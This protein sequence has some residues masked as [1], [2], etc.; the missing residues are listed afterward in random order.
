MAVRS[1][2]W[3]GRRTRILRCAAT[4]AS[5]KPPY[6]SGGADPARRSGR[7]GSIAGDVDRGSC[8]RGSQPGK[9]QGQQIGAIRLCLAGPR[10]EPGTLLKGKHAITFDFEGGPLAIAP[11]EWG[12]MLARASASERPPEAHVFLR[13]ARHARNI[14]RHRRSV[15][16]SA[17]AAEL[18]LARLRDDE[19]AGSKARLGNYVRERAQQIGGLTQFLS[20][21]GRTLPK[22][23]QQEVGEPRNRAIHEGHEPDEETATKALEKAEEVVDLAFP[24]RKLL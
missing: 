15:L 17:T 13:D 1:S 11:R 24:W 22:R 20:E 7:L 2:L 21:M 10:Q 16:D 4:G 3:M 12:R 18:S 19:L 6:S 8:A 5:E 23:I 14:G 9:G